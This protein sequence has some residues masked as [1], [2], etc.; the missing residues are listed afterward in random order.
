MPAPCRKGP[1]VPRSPLLLL[2]VLALLL[3]CSTES[4]SSETPATA[5]CPTFEVASIGLV[6]ALGPDYPADADTYV[7]SSGVSLTTTGALGPVISLGE[8]ALTNLL[9]DQVEAAASARGIDLTLTR[10]GEL[11]V[12]DGHGFLGAG[13]GVDYVITVESALEASGSIASCGELPKIEG[14]EA[15]LRIRSV[16]AAHVVNWLGGR[17]AAGPITVGSES[18]RAAELI[19]R[20][21]VAGRSTQEPNRYQPWPAGTTTVWSQGDLDAIHARYCPA[22]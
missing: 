10:A 5:V 22:P 21:D 1:L 14:G 16:G 11:P 3:A 19:R 17:C 20:D 9:L 4:G 6:A 18:T 2:P 8:P 12:D 7:A 15:G 13:D